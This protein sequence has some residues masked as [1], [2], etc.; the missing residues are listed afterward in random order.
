MENCKAKDVSLIGQI[1]AA[2]WVAAWCAT[3]FIS[4]GLQNI[5]ITDIILSGCGEAAC[6]TPVYFSIVMDKIKDIRFG[7]S[8]V[9]EKP[10]SEVVTNL[11][12]P[13]TVVQKPEVVK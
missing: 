11:I 7:T 13:D 5:Q 8:A 1:V 6:F 10:I 3:K 9:S 4:G 12:T 2:V